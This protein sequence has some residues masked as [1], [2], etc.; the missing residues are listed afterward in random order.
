MHVQT[1]LLVSN[2]G[3]CNHATIAG[4]LGLSYM[5]IPDAAPV[6]QQLS[7]VSRPVTTMS[8]GAS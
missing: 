7:G 4:E 3:V 8:T 5:R 6:P 1:R 2:S